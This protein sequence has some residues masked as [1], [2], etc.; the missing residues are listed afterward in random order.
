MSVALIPYPLD[1][2]PP[3]LEVHHWDL[4]GDV[5]P[6]VLDRVEFY[7]TPY[8]FRLDTI[9]IA[10]RMP[11]LQVLQALTAGVDHAL[12]HVRPG[13]TLCNARGVHDTATSELAVTLTLAALNDVASWVR[14][15]DTERWEPAWRSGLADRRVLV[16]GAGAIGSAIAARLRP[17]EC[18]VATV[19][20]TARDG[21]GGVADLPALLPD[22]DVVV[23][24]IPLTDETRHLVDAAFLAALPDGA[25]VVNVARGPVVDTGA[26]VAELATGRLRAAMDV[27]DPEPLPPGHP[28][29]SLALISPH[30]GGWAD[31]FRPRA[32]RLIR[33]QLA[34]W[35]A[36]DPLQNVV[37]AG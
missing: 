28:L 17:F 31:C 32:E 16:I 23:L 14:A 11:R 7:V 13:I 1:D 29:W 9:T 30:V 15:G 18:A 12:P 27:T 8:S 3:Q 5:P 35:V 26:L 37:S 20:R 22:T 25:L 19:G 6:E 21:V 4:D 33:D 24:V 36:G 34:R 2:L 10:G